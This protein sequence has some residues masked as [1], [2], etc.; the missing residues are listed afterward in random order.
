MFVRK[1]NKK[2][3]SAEIK[4]ISG[5]RKSYFKLHT[6]F[7]DAAETFTVL[8]C[9]QNMKLSELKFAL[10]MVAGIPMDLQRLSYIDRGRI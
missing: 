10:E 2:H 3:V 7:Q 4:C 5:S 8:K 9:Y 1:S 6:K